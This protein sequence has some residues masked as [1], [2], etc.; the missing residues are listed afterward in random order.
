MYWMEDQ[1]ICLLTYQLN[2]AWRV[3]GGKRKRKYVTV[4]VWIILCCHMEFN[5]F[6]K[7]RED[8]HFNAICFIIE[9]SLF[10]VLLLPEGSY[11]VYSILAEKSL[12]SYER[13][14]SFSCHSWML[15]IGLCFS[16]A[17]IHQWEGALGAAE[18]CP[19]LLKVKC[20][21]PGC[22][23][24]CG[25]RGMGNPTTPTDSDLTALSILTT[26]P[27]HCAINLN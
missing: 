10:F 8:L 23:R 1:S 6:F 24:N 3:E 12:L 14:S 19:P 7:K 5:W 26:L 27:L 9:S 25:R 22:C 4:I 21:T 2:Q 11:S 18:Y 16:E 20:V 15:W 17:E 13:L